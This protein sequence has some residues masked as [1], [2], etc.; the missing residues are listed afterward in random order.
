MSLANS[1]SLLL[2]FLLYLGFHTLL[3]FLRDSHRLIRYHEVIIVKTRLLILILGPYN[4][5]AVF[6][7]SLAH[8]EALGVY[9]ELVADHLLHAFHYCYL[10]D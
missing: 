8:D 10:Q 6:L 7:V 1:A 9:Y 5:A 2:L 3:L 4:C